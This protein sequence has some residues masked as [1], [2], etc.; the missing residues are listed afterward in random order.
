MDKCYKEEQVDLFHH[1]ARMLVAGF[2]NSGKSELVAKL[3][4]KYH[5][6][7]SHIFVCGTTKHP[8]QKVSSIKNKLYLHSKIIDPLNEIE[9]GEE[10]TI[11][12]ILDDIFLEAVESRTVVDAFIKGRHHN[13]SVILIT[14]NLYFQGKFA[15]TI[16]LNCTHYL[17][18]RM[19]DLNQ[20]EC[21]SRQIHGSGLS[22]KFI[23]V[24]KTVVLQKPYGY[25]LVDL[26]INTHEDLHLRSLIAGE[27]SCEVVYLKWKE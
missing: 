6:K 25:L 8:L 3:V 24:Y 27:A 15:R 13:M 4:D 10:A 9:E 7:F 5:F 22:K 18:L 20:I 17:L 26:S 23:E 12:F 2:S 11:L 1:P 21:L 14:Q 19:R 16:S